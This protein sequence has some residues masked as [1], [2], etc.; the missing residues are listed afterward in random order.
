MDRCSSCGHAR[1]EHWPAASVPPSAPAVSPRCADSASLRGA[2]GPPPCPTG[3][4]RQAPS[5]LSG[6]SPGPPRTGRR[7]PRP[8][9]RSPRGGHRAKTRRRGSSGRRRLHGLQ[10]P[11]GIGCLSPH[12]LEKSLLDGFGDRS[13]KEWLQGLAAALDAA[14]AAAVSRGLANEAS[15]IPPGGRCWPQRGVRGASQPKRRS[16]PAAAGRRSAPP[17]RPGSRVSCPPSG[18]L[19]FIPI[20]SLL[21]ATCSWPSYRRGF[22][23]PRWLSGGWC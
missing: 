3:R 15:R 4:S 2:G 6:R 10:P 19:P 18:M 21:A 7:S 13:W 1:A 14:H 17:R 8:D 9:T 11:V 16:S 23:R 22:K 20:R 12:D 5:I